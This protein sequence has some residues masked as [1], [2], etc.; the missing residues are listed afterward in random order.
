MVPGYIHANIR[1]HRGHS[2]NKVNQKQKNKKG[3]DNSIFFFVVVVFSEFFKDSY[4]LC[5]ELFYRIK[6]YFHPA[7][8]FITRKKVIKDI[9]K[10]NKVVQA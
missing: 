4:K 9:D 1:I 7:K 3:K 5:L 8:V 10:L 6:I 2:I